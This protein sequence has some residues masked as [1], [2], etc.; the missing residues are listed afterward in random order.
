MRIL[1][2][3]KNIYYN[4]S[5]MRKGNFYASVYGIIK[6][7]DGDVLVWKRWE[8]AQWFQWRF[9]IPAGHIDW[10]ESVFQALQ[11]EMKEELTID[12]VEN[13]VCLKHTVHRTLEDGREYFDFYFVI[14]KFEWNVKIWEPDKCSELKYVAEKDLSKVALLKH[15]EMALHYINDNILFSECTLRNDEY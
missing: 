3:Y 9:Q 2:S 5:I 8:K 6:N 11:R 10:K 14:E 4:K 7:K 13:N 12:I 1:S 15:D